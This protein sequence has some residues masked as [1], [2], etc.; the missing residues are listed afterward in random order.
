M[1]RC[2]ICDER[3]EYPGDSY[4]AIMGGKE[5]PNKCRVCV[6]CG[7]REAQPDTDDCVEC[8]LRYAAEVMQSKPM[9]SEDWNDA[10]QTVLQIREATCQRNS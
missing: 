7:M 8:A 9:G 10:Y 2:L 5:C 3:M 6:D 4:D 1:P